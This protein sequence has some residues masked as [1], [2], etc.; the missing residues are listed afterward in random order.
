DPARR[1]PAPGRGR[2]G[3]G[4]KA[5]ALWPL[6]KLTRLP[7][8][9]TVPGDVLAGAAWAAGPDEDVSVLGLVCSSCLAYVAGM[10]LNDWADREEDAR[11]RPN[12]PIPSGD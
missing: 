12:R 8:V 4:V 2:R 1:R 3:A 10:A 9:V 6:V 7:S 11:E 5:P